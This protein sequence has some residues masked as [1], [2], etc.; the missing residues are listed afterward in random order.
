VSGVTLAAMRERVALEE[1]VAVADGAGGSIVSW[2]EVAELWAAIRPRA[3]GEGV[4][5]GGISGRVTHDIT[6]R[7]RDGVVAP[8]RFRQGA[9][10]F[11]IKAVIDVENAHRFLKCLVEEGVA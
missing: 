9:R 1:P 7:F 3:G 10:L 6:I 11:D 5:A 4:E 8:Q 2:V